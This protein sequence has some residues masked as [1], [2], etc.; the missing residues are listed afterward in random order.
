MRCIF[1]LLLLL[2]LFSCKPVL[3]KNIDVLRFKLDQL[4]TPRRSLPVQQLK[5]IGGSGWRYENQVQY[6]ECLNLN[7]R[8]NILYPRWQCKLDVP[9]NTY[10]GSTYV[11]CEGYEFPDDP[12]ITNGSCYLEYVL[13]DKNVI[14]ENHIL[15]VATCLY[16]IIV[17]LFYICVCTIHKGTLSLT[18]N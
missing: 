2:P 1:I 7:Y 14:I 11:V 17:F 4:T 3:L 9:Q 5:F 16:S 18:W 15:I 12:Y 6:G 8:K 13:L 10:V